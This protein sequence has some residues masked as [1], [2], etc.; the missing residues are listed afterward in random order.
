V[1]TSHGSS[2]TTSN[3]FTGTGPIITDFSPTVGAMNTYVTID[4][5]N[6][7]SAT[8]VTVNG[9]REF[10]TAQTPL[11]INLTNNPGTGPIKVVTPDGHR[12]NSQQF[13]QHRGAVHH[14]FL[15]R[16]GVRPAPRSRLTG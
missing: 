5:V 8:S 7:S 2:T 11:Q 13:H 3:F 10:I 14:R 4:G 1:T 9:V 16:A 12:S 15:S 6:L